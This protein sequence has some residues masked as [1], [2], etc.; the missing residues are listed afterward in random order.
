M[1]KLSYYSSYYYDNIGQ[2]IG[3]VEYDDVGNGRAYDALGR[4]MG[5]TYSGRTYNSY[6]DLV[7]ES[8][9]LTSLLVKEERVA[10]VSIKRKAIGPHDYYS[11]ETEDV[12]GLGEEPTKKYYE[13]KKKGK[14]E[15]GDS[16]DTPYGQGRIVSKATEYKP[17][18][19]GVKISETDE[20]EMVEEQDITLIKSKAASRKIRKYSARY[21]VRFLSS[22]NLSIYI[23]DTDFE[24][25]PEV[26]AIIKSDSSFEDKVSTI[27]SVVNRIAYEK[28]TE[29]LEDAVD[30]TIEARGELD[31]VDDSI[32]WE[33]FIEEATRVESSN[34]VV[35]KRVVSDKKVGWLRD[36]WLGG[37]KKILDALSEVSTLF[38]R[39]MRDKNGKG[40]DLYNYYSSG[41]Y[42]EIETPYSQGS[43]TKDQAKSLVADLINQFKT[44]LYALYDVSA[45]SEEHVEE[46]ES[47]VEQSASGAGVGPSSHLRRFDREIPE[48]E[49][50]PYGHRQ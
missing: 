7:A 16:V 24:Y 6:G 28:L 23:H 26:E 27:K 1:N 19:Y 50:P 39:E 25:D 3:S 4:Y 15:L 14:Y 10:M 9:I 8:D 13:P 2:V 34:K 22:P 36:L 29:A 35:S 37:S 45:R 32:D 44:E 5:E 30:I 20:L 40:L 31:L 12:G 46:K 38:A 17:Y 18:A 33:E 21:M 48:S 11:I 41:R 47:T 43:I 49:H 42:E